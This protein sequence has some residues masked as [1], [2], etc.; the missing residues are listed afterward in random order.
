MNERDRSKVCDRGRKK[1]AQQNQAGEE[2]PNCLSQFSVSEKERNIETGGGKKLF[3]L[4]FL[5]HSRP[6]TISRCRCLPHLDSGPYTFSWGLSKRQKTAHSAGNFWIIEYA[7]DSYWEYAWGDNRLRYCLQCK[8]FLESVFPQEDVF[9]LMWQRSYHA[10]HTHTAFLIDHHY[11]YFS[12]FFL[13]DEKK[14]DSLW[15]PL[16]PRSLF[17]PQEMEVWA[18]IEHQ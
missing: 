11:Y 8:F 7:V 15:F 3:F 4:A 1:N 2:I 14:I 17:R 18:A 9:I 12:R 6:K 13:E 10:I 16:L 5:F